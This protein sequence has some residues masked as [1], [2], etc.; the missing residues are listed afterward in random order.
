MRETVVQATLHLE[1]VLGL[2]EERDVALGE[3]LERLLMCGIA[4]RACKHGRNAT[5]GDGAG[6]EEGGDQL[7]T[8]GGDGG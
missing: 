8:H 2:L 1:Q 3:G 7:S 5:D 6:A 4:G